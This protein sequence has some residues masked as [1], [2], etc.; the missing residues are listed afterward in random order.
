[1]TMVLVTFAK[2]KVTPAEGLSKNK[3]RSLK[4]SI[5]AKN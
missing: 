1:M 4:D 2:T 3:M 5:E